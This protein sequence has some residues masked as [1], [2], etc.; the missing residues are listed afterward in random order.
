MPPYNLIMCPSTADSKNSAKRTGKRTQ[1]NT[2]VT[3]TNTFKT[4]YR[5]IYCPATDTTYEGHIIHSSSSKRDTT[6]ASANANVNTDC[7]QSPHTNPP[8]ANPTANPRTGTAAAAATSTAQI[9]MSI[10]Y[11]RHGKGMLYDHSAHMSIEGYWDQN[12]LIGHALQT[13][14][15]PP[16]L[17]V[18]AKVKIKMKHAEKGMRN[19]YMHM[20]R[21]RSMSDVRGRIMAQ[22]EGTFLQTST[23]TNTNTTIS[24]SQ[25]QS[26][27]KPKSS[28]T[29]HISPSRHETK[30]TFERHGTGKY[31]FH[32]TSDTYS[33]QFQHNLFHGMGTFIWAST[34]DR[35]DGPFKK[36]CMHATRTK[37]HARA[38]AIK[39][40]GIAVGGQGGVGGGGDGVVSMCVGRKVF[41]NGD[42]FEGGFR[43][44]RGNGW[45]TMMFSNGDCFVGMYS[46]DLVRIFGIYCT[47]GILHIQYTS[48]RTNLP[49]ALSICLPACHDSIE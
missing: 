46:K 9:P 28:K 23:N 22:Y 49:V 20:A 12:Q 1:S 32:T 17:K 16:K 19:M 45:G 47:Y 34:N 39:A 41:G 42:V 27:D 30:P 8:N 36:G 18:K 6:I 5:I 48:F 14:Y 24:A 44:G 25:S 40:K 37:A 31:T 29:D 15:E 26:L 7:H 2:G 4:V 10:Q 43:K 3:R 38:R 13:L 35:Y 21:N 11:I 33:G